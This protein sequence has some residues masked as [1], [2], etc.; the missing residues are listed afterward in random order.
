[1]PDAWNIFDF[2]VVVVSLLSNFPGM[3]HLPGINLLRLVR[4]FRVVR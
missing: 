2:V 4:V 3:D 1:M